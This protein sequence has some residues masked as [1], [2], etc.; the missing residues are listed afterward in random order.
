MSPAV[1]YKRIS[2]PSLIRTGIGERHA[3][4]LRV[5]INGRIAQL[6]RSLVAVAVARHSASEGVKPIT[7]A[8]TGRSTCMPLSLT[9]TV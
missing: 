4:W 8:I 7:S 1:P 2:P 9:D 3:P 5:D 6:L